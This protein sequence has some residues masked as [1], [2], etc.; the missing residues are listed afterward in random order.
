MILQELILRDFGIYGGEHCFSLEPQS[1]KPV[2]LFRGHNGAGKTTFLD[3]IR[4]A[5]Y[6]K[7]AIGT[8]VG[9]V[10][11]ENHLARRVHAAS[12][13]RSAS[14]TLRFG[15]IESGKPCNYEVERSWSVRGTTVVETFSL[16]SDGEV[17]SQLEPDEWQDYVTE[18]VPY[19]VSQ[20]FFFDGEKIQDIADSHT[21]DGVK[22]SI[23]SLLGLD[24][25]DQ[26]RTDLALYVTRSVRTENEIEFE[27]LET[28]RSQLKGELIDLEQTRADLASR[29]DQAEARVR[30]AE[31]LFRN[32]GGRLAS[33]REEAM[34]AL[35]AAEAQREELHQH[36]RQI[37]GSVLPLGLAPNLLARFKALLDEQVEIA[38]AEKVSAIVDRFEKATDSSGKWSAIHFAEFRAFLSITV[39][40]ANRLHIEGSADEIADRLAALTPG[41]ASEAQILAAQLE[42]NATQRKLLQDQLEG[43]DGGLAQDALYSLKTAERECGAIAHELGRLDEEIATM[44][45]RVDA[46]GQTLQRLEDAVFD[47]RKE[48]RS[49]D[50]AGKA[51]AALIDY[52]HRLLEKRTAELGE[53]FAFSFN[54]LIRKHGFV[55]EI[56]VDPSTFEITLIGND[57]SEITRNSLS[58]GERQI[59]AVSMLWALGKTSGRALPLV[60]DT[61]L[62]RLDRTHRSRII[63]QYLGGASH[64]VIL[65]CTD[66]EL[67]DD[68]EQ[69]L[70]P[71]VSRAYELGVPAS[72]RSTTTMP[73][74]F[75]RELEAVDADH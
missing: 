11:Y 62:S 50:L 60:I 67:T 43:F 45:R 25:V 19:G 59:F 5:L 30:R 22:E 41:L 8:R 70:Q 15:R 28:E 61:P 66:S 58:A 16:T 39:P 46:I 9:Q 68:I 2:I 23:R 38:D 17:V 3:A 27:S 6:G 75:A 24:L 37:A 12:A 13:S 21:T 72:S 57:G 65:L 69:Q 36:L 18:L 54:R 63:E 40:Q 20:L 56:R 32:E 47:F 71:F 73:M 7:R 10:E 14:I 52:Q 4:L 35:R 42:K 48:R 31:E 33:N 74:H 34:L 1:D 53:H 44:R 64:Q 29:R 55:D 51:R 26:L 49:V